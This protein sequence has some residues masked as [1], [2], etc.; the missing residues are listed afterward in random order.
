MRAE[1]PSAS[2]SDAD[3]AQVVAVTNCDPE[4]ARFLLEAAGGSPDAAI[5]LFLGA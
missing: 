2:I 1:E 4:S 5:H 3:V